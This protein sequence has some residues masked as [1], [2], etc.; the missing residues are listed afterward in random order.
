MGSVVMG[1]TIVFIVF[2]HSLSLQ[3]DNYYTARQ[4]NL[5]DLDIV[6]EGLSSGKPLTR[7]F[8]FDGERVVGSLIRA[9][10]LDWNILVVPHRCG[11]PFGAQHRQD[12]HYSPLPG[13]PSCRRPVAPHVPFPGSKI[14]KA[15][16]P[17]PTIES[18]EEVGDWPKGPVREFNLLGDALH[19]MA[20]ALHERE[21]RLNDQLHFLQQLLNSIPIP[22][23]YKDVDGVGTYSMK[24]FGEKV[25]GGL[26]AFTTSED[27]GTTFTLTLMQA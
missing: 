1:S 25:L 23:Y 10:L 15:P 11:L 5:T 4:Y 19:S 12:L 20:N 6:R 7:S 14:G 13:P 26:V 27:I 3:V 24:F 2:P 18:G 16:I 9:P 8:S 17:C 22:V 21:N